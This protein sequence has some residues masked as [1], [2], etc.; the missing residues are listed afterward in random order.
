MR[1]M[2]ITTDLVYGGL[3]AHRH[4][5]PRLT[6]SHSCLT[7]CSSIQI[8][9]MRGRCIPQHKRRCFI[10]HAVLSTPVLFGALPPPPRTQRRDGTGLTSVPRA[11]Q[12]IDQC[13]DNRAYITGKL[14]PLLREVRPSASC[15]LQ[16]AWR[17]PGCSPIPSCF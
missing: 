16:G 1:G 11:W 13:Y 6:L 10:G 12:L 15:E 4:R 3:V 9:Y 5:M 7:A 8:I 17:W 14:I 2:G